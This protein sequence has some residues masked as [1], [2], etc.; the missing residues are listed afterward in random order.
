MAE[1]PSGNQ[2]ASPAIRPLDVFTGSTIRR[3]YRNEVLAVINR[4]ATDYRQYYSGNMISSS[5]GEAW[6][7]PLGRACRT[8][9]FWGQPSCYFVEGEEERACILIAMGVDLRRSTIY[10]KYLPPIMP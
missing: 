1:Q 4:R 2:T 3:K 6:T 10:K 7:L 9:A 8:P 5:E